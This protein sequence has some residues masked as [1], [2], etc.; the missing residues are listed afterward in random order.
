MFVRIPSLCCPAAEEYCS[1]ASCTVQW[2][3]E[4]LWA[5]HTVHSRCVVTGPSISRS[6]EKLPTVSSSVRG[7]VTSVWFHQ[8]RLGLGFEVPSAAGAVRVSHRQLYRQTATGTSSPLL[9]SCSNG[10][11]TITLVRIFE[12]VY[13]QDQKQTAACPKLTWDMTT[14]W[15]PS[16]GKQFVDYQTV[17][18]RPLI[19]SP[20]SQSVFNGKMQNIQAR[21]SVWLVKFLTPVNTM[22]TCK[23]V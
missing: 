5:Y 10:V 1:T 18:Q 9:C 7:I 20:C 19:L 8:R 22:Y 12:F 14:Y 2:I 13:I 3:S 23:Q 16:L 17:D 4:L 15:L 21:L 11:N 6:T